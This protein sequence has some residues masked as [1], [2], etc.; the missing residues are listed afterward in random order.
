M[1]GAE[2][3]DEEHRRCNNRSFIKPGQ[4]ERKSE[5]N[6]FNLVIS[7]FEGLYSGFGMRSVENTATQNS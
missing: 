6:V 3:I 5:L 4:R 1:N 7:F 2:E